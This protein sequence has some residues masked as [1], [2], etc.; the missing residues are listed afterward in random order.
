MIQ[1]GS[2]FSGPVPVPAPLSPILALPGVGPVLGGKFYPQLARR[3]GLEYRTYQSLA[4]ITASF[5]GWAPRT[6]RF[7]G[8][9]SQSRA[10]VHISRRPRA[11]APGHAPRKEEENAI[12]PPQ[13]QQRT[14]VN[15]QIRFSPVRLI[16]P[17]G[18]QIG[19]VPIEEAREHAEKHELDLVEISAESRPI[20]C[21]I[22]DWGK[23]RYD[24]AKKAKEAK[25]HQILIEVKEVKYRPMI[26]D[27]DFDTKTNRARRFL[28]GGKKVK[29]TIM[30]RGRDMR[31]PE[32]GFRILDRV[33]EELKEIATVGDR[34]RRLIGRD[35]TMTLNPLAANKK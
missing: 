24:Q 28:E 23:Y 19:I 18:E 30:F 7:P 27:H 35:L 4:D 20:V 13:Q 11:Q 32:N 14:R 10:R 34:A 3:P 33:A 2:A 15:E 31:R 8:G 25:K 21:K 17:D 16:G 9:R 29:V 1:A 12:A 5:P 22:M 26:D 6:T